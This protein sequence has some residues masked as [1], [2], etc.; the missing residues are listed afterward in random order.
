MTENL[1]EIWEKK[2]KE[3]LLGDKKAAERAE[4]DRVSP[5]IYDGPDRQRTAWEWVY[6]W[7]IPQEITA[8]YMKISQPAV[9]QL[10]DNYFKRYP[11]LRPRKSLWLMGKGWLPPTPKQAPKAG[12][13]GSGSKDAAG[14][15]AESGHGYHKP[16]KVHYPSEKEG[17]KRRARYRKKH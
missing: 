5:F 3:A 9:S 1:Q 17:Q 4:A 6:K 13:G 14:I 8:L 7:R 15:F 16:H 10:L 11:D 12:E 2:L